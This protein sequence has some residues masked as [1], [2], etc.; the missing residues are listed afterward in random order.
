MWIDIPTDGAVTR[1]TISQEWFSMMQ[2][3]AHHPSFREHCIDRYFDAPAQADG[4][5]TE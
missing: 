4:R 3:I 1:I 5:D 2:L